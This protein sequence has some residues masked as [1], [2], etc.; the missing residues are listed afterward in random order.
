MLTVALRILLTL[1]DHHS[2]DVTHELA[3]CACEAAVYAAV[4]PG[5]ADDATTPLGEALASLL[6]RG[7]ALSG[8]PDDTH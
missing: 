6:C 5:A 2:T 8:Q 1:T 3:H 4:A 7:E